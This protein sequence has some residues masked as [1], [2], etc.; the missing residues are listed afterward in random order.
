LQKISKCFQSQQN[1]NGPTLE[2]SKKPNI[3]LTGTC[4]TTTIDVK[5]NKKHNRSN[6]D[7]C[8]ILVFVYFQF[9]K[10]SNKIEINGIAITNGQKVD[11]N[12][13][14]HHKSGHGN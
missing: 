12:A 5:L 6:G 8:F 13:K 10:S 9:P 3:R 4:K 7:G 11:G 2:V 1:F 14:I